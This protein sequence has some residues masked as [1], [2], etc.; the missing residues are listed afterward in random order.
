M[1]HYLLR[2]ITEDPP[3]V[4]VT[5]FAATD[6]RQAVRDGLACV[7]GFRTHG[8]LDADRVVIDTLEIG[9]FNRESGEI[10]TRS[11]MRLYDSAEPDL[12]LDV[13]APVPPST[14]R[15]AIGRGP[16]LGAFTD[17]FEEFEEQELAEIG[18]PQ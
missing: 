16:S 17:T 1:P 2:L 6:D 7:A 18:H 14:G 11:D 12:S 13:D 8:L 15:L 4:A 5:P 10:Q 3:H 9:F